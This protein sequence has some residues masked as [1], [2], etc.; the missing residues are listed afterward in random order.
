MCSYHLSTFVSSFTAKPKAPGATVSVFLD[1]TE[2]N[3]YNHEVYEDMNPVYVGLILLAMC[4]TL[5]V[6]GELMDRHYK[7]NTIVPTH[8][9]GISL[10][11]SVV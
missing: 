9:P 3:D 6:L 2:D 7:K 8:T 4:V 5:I 11:Q 1:D 10:D